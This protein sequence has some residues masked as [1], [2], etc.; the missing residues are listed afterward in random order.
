MSGEGLL[1]P[2]RPTICNPLRFY[3]SFVFKPAH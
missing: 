1:T 3:G 2:K